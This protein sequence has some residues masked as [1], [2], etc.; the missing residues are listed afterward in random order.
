VLLDEDPLAPGADS[1]GA[2]AALRGMSVAMTAVG[3]RVVHS[4]L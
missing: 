4:T 1:A 2:G 3:G